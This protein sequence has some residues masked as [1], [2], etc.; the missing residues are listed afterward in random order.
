MRVA[1]I[2]AGVAGSTMA[3]MLARANIQT[4]LFEQRDSLIS[5]PPFCHLHAGGNLYPDIS[6]E[7]C[8]KLLHQSIDFAKLYPFAIDYRPTLI[9]FPK[10][11]KI[12]VE[13][14]IPRLDLLKSEYQK[15]V[16]NDPSKDILGDPAYYYQLYTK[17]DLE[18]LS[19]KPTPK[20]PKS[21]DEWLIEPSKKIDF[22]QVQTP[23]IA[24][25]EFGINLFLV[26][27]FLQTKLSSY[28]SLEISFNSKV[29]SIK[30]EK[31]K[32]LITVNENEYHFDYLI[33]AT[34]FQTGIIDDM[35][36]LDEKRMVEFK[37]AYVTKWDIE[38]DIWPE[39]IFH[40]KRGTKNGMGQFTPYP[41]S[42]FQLHGMSKNITLFKE[43]LAKSSKISSYP[44]LP[45]KL[46][47]KIERGW[48]STDIEQRTKAAILHISKF[49]P[50]FKSAK[51][52]SK[53]LFGAQQIPGDDPSLRVAEV[54]FPTKNYARCEIVKVS[55]VVDMAKAILEDM[56]IKDDNL[57]SPLN[58]VDIKKVKSL[59]KEI[60]TKRGYPK[61]LSKQIKEQ[62]S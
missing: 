61:D 37:A 26:S 53:P 19:K 2:G 49:I 60:A 56:G 31:E 13:N 25:S 17:E 34:G 50:S 8:L 59:A 14:F 58:D 42:H 40:G 20:N 62:R 47:N 28:S 27:G 15:I 18:K 35:L 55:S 11:C 51:V 48:S 4:T 7:Q 54:S 12:G 5:G 57:F 33:N 44:L 22:S 45:K 23:I 43:G 1:I 21:L 46:I 3:L 41:N 16:Q 24:V 10:S 6:D 39:I 29:T 30:K 52:A 9:I 32:F 36:G 38:S